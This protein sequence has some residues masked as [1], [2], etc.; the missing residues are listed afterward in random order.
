MTIALLLTF[1]VGLA[2]GIPVALTMGLSTFIA[3]LV[4]GTVPLQVLPQRI[5]SG[6]NS[7][8]MMTIPLFILA[9]DLMTAGR[10]TDRLITFSNNLVGHICGGLGHV[11]V[12][13][14]MMFAG[15]SGSAL[16]N[17]A[18]PG[19]IIMSMMRKAGYNP[20]YSGSLTAAASV[21]GMI[22]PPSIIMI[23]YALTDSR[24]TVVGL[25]LAG[26][27]PGILLGLALMSYN[28][29]ISVRK[30][31]RFQLEPPPFIALI[32]SFFHAL[33]GI[34]MPIIILGGIHGGIFT[35]TEASAVA[36]TYALFVGLF[37]TKGLTLKTL[38][39]I[40]RKS[41][42]VSASVLLIVAMGSS[43][44]WALTYAQVPQHV[45]EVISGLSDNPVILLLIIALF[46][47]V[48]GMFV[49][50]LPAVIILVPV[51]VPVAVKLGIDPTQMAMVII[52][53]LG[54][55]MLT[56][57]VAPLLFVVSTVGKLKFERLAM[58]IIPFIIVELIIVLLII[59]FPQIAT[60][61]P[62]FL[63]YD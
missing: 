43:F 36:V 21:I 48:T 58:T 17:A 6:I 40:F 11:N 19:A 56:P 31:Y 15:I 41:A 49:D 1:F 16:A 33:P 24:V 42:I 5:F 7:F 23:I 50:T 28:V 27:I 30:G 3:F 22:I 39:D 26:I 32:K 47:M 35:P 2:I 46:T 61:L 12:L 10:L 51:L 37:I 38:P 57:P 62:T 34:F 20:Y 13:V 54:I 14:N 53:C 55:G 9:A 8:P 29:I 18:G 52:L 44:S 4:D 25:F 60:W 45:A 63:G 59:V